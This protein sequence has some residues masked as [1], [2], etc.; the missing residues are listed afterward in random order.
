MNVLTKFHFS[1]INPKIAPKILK[2]AS[3]FLDFFTY[4]EVYDDLKT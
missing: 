1:T 4:R 3:G 2:M